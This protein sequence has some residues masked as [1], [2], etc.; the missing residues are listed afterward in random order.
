MD[1]D[2]V[3]VDQGS[4][5]LSSCDRCPFTTKYK[6]NLKRHMDTKHRP[7]EAVHVPSLYVC[8]HCGAVFQ[9]ARGLSCHVRGKHERVFRLTCSVCRKGF[10]DGASYRG[11]LAKH[12]Q[13]REIP[14]E[15]CGKRFRFASN[16]ARHV[17]VSYTHLTL[18]T[19]ST[20]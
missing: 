6:K 5:P 13:S 14:C 12:D 15:R 17:P 16:L 1:G 19:S 3:D 10:N 11:H 4:E 20:V 8:E 7:P 2:D 18:P 9:S